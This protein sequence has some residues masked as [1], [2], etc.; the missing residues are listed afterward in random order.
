[1]R[2]LSISICI[3]YLIG[4]L[5]FIK[6]ENSSF[7]PINSLTTEN[8]PEF[9]A[10]KNGLVLSVSLPELVKDLSS[11]VVKIQLS[12]STGS[13]ISFRDSTGLDGFGFKLTDLSQQEIT[14]T[15]KHK[16]LKEGGL[17]FVTLQLKAGSA[18]VMTVPLSDYY[19]LNEAGR[20]KIKISWKKLIMGPTGWIPEP[21]PEIEVE[22]KIVL[23]KTATGFSITTDK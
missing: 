13:D 4:T 23:T 12:N 6:A 5:N 22:G 15:D 14:L 11:L 8:G 19:K 18:L 9:H 17:G 16:R 1:M 20:Y 7:V 3:L 10:S 2:A 21:T